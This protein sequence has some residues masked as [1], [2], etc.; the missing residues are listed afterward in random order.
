MG[1]SFYFLGD[2]AADTPDWRIVYNQK[3]AKITAWGFA[4]IGGPL[5]LIGG[6]ILFTM[7]SGL[8]KLTGLDNESLLVPR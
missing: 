3:V 4:V 7:I 2:L 6:Y 8:K 5:M 1:L